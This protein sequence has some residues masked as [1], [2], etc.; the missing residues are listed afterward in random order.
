[1]A[2]AWRDILKKMEVS[3]QQKE[4]WEEKHPPITRISSQ[5]ADNKRNL[6]FVGEKAVTCNL[7]C[8]G[9]CIPNE[10]NHAQGIVNVFRM[11]IIVK[12]WENPEEGSPLYFAGTC[13]LT[14]GK[15]CVATDEKLRRSVER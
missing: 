13:D 12:G 6:Q 11:G 10:Y 2:K 5:E 15:I 1:M 4:E 8:H 3:H 7:P 9:Q 14:N